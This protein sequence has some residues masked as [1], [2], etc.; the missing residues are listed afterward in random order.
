[1]NRV[2]VHLDGR[3]PA[4]VPCRLANG[5]A[6]FEALAFRA[7]G[8][9]THAQHRSSCMSELWLCTR[10][11]VA[12]LGASLQTAEHSAGALRRRHQKHGSLLRSAH[13]TPSSA[14]APRPG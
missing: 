5:W 7:F 2:S 12:P 14:R 3:P 6:V 9:D 10:D 13:T 1:M 8:L 4:L 11:G